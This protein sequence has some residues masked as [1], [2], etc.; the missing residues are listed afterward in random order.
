MILYLQ[1]ITEHKQESPLYGQ[2]VPHMPVNFI[3]TVSFL[4]SCQ[5]ECLQFSMSKDT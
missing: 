5:Y 1:D 4:L 2:T 3:I